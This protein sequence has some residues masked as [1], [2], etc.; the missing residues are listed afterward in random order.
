[1]TCSPQVRHS[2]RATTPR[3]EVLF[4]A[5]FQMALAE[6]DDEDDVADT[7]RDRLMK[8]VVIDPLAISR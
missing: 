1:M 2:G 5:W 4:W 6:S 3:H 8:L 7:V